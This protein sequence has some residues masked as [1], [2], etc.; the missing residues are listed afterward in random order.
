MA[1]TSKLSRAAARQRVANVRKYAT[2][3]PSIRHPQ[4]RL[5][6]SEPSRLCNFDQIY[7]PAIRLKVE[8]F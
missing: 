7:V 4:W 1:R 3:I 5:I 2:V 8:E 6:T